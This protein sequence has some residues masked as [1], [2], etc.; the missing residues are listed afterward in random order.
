MKKKLCVTCKETKDENQ[1]HLDKTKSD[2]KQLECKACK[3]SRY[4]FNKLDRLFVCLDGLVFSVLYLYKQKYKNIWLH[5]CV[6]AIN[7]NGHRR[8][9][10]NEDFLNIKDDRLWE[11]AI[12]ESG[13][14]YEEFVAELCE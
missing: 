4:G 7:G 14:K 10:V 9:Y 13:I 5:E 6:C 12:Y 1:F 11:Y 8:I 3:N 2:G